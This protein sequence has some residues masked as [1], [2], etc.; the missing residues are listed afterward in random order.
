MLLITL[1]ISTLKNMQN[2]ILK[3]EG[4]QRNVVVSNLSRWVISQ[5]IIINQQKSLWM[6]VVKAAKNQLVKQRNTSHNVQVTS[7]GINLPKVCMI[8]RLI[9]QTQEK[10][11][12]SMSKKSVKDGLWQTSHLI[13][14]AEHILTASA[15][16]QNQYRTKKWPKLCMNI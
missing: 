14:D 7:N 1:K 13:L 2:M 11:A 12:P 6:P 5:R 9:C 15:T 8:W 4:L 3:E 10:S 16:S